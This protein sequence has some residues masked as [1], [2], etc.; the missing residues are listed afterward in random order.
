MS[1]TDGGQA[2]VLIMARAPRRGEVRQALEPLLGAAACLRLHT[3]LILSTAAWGAAVAGG[4]VHLAHEPPDAAPEL[5]R[6]LA[7]VPLLPQNGDGLAARVGD[8]ASRVFAHHHGPLLIVWPD[9]P[10]LL[11]AH[12]AAALSDLRDGCRLV[13][14]PTVDGGL[15]MIGLSQV[16]PELF[17]IPERVW[18]G[19]DLVA[20]AYAA[21]A[22][23]KLQVGLL[24]AER[25]LRRPA[26][27][28]AALADP[29]LPARL[30]RILEPGRAPVQ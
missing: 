14:G 24:R 9:L 12:A 4:R 30:R 26:D 18:R 11:P 28:R 16:I 21:S 2:A 27:V 8:A 19:G 22:A 13:L 25:G 3:E 17:A 20:A 10:R 29:L 15:Y 5:R 7:G 1:G 23:A 6:L